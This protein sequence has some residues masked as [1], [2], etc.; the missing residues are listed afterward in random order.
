MRVG[1]G[2]RTDVGR[3]RNHNEDDFVVGQRLWLV[4]DGMGGHAAGD[5]ASS[6]VVQAFRPLAEC[7]E[8]R[9]AD[10][11]EAVRAANRS[12]ID[13][14]A[15][16]ADARGLG[17]TVTGVAVVADDQGRDFVVFN[18]GD[19]RVYRFV[20]GT[21]ERVS[22]DHSEVE[23][24]VQAGVITAEEARVH[25]SRNIVTR[26]L[27]SQLEPDVDLFRC[28]A[29]PAQRFVVCSDGLN[30]EVP[31]DL[32]A[33]ILD[34]NPGPEQAADALVAAALE[35]GGHD[36]VTVIVVDAVR[37]EPAS[38]GEGETA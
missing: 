33:A 31:D 28:A 2:A 1:T 17:S 37:D 35:H 19:S 38:R 21:L 32:I 7:D 8:L 15:Q 13:Y 24:L 6:L 30:T 25:P 14:G 18:V 10:V 23:E 27:G 34:E 22:V 5:V 36:N 12:V 29:L 26:S 20:E 3:V 4:A 16:H 9:V 11:V